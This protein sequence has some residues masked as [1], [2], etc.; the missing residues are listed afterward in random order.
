MESLLT[1]ADNLESLYAAPK[2]DENVKF[3]FW[4]NYFKFKLEFLYRVK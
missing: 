2:K 1:I 4:S 3:P